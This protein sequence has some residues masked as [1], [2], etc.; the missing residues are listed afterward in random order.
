MVLAEKRSPAMR[1]EFV[2]PYETFCLL[3]VG[4]ETRT[5]KL[6][7]F[8]ILE[9]ARVP[10]TRLVAPVGTKIGTSRWPKAIQA[11]VTATAASDTSCACLSEDLVRFTRKAFKHSGYIRLAPSVNPDTSAG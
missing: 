6:I 11:H 3:H 8:K 5:C 4:A 2:Q 9:H 7:T 1:V 10:D